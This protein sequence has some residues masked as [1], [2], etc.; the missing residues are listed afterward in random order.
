MRRGWRTLGA[1][2]A[3][4]VVYTLFFYRDLLFE[5]RVTVFRDQYA[6]LL[7]L[8][9]VVRFLS[10]WSW[11]PLWTPFQVL[12][13]PLAADPLAAVYYPPNWGLRLLPFPLGYNASL[14]VHHALAV[15]GLY[16]LLRRRGSGREAAAF[17]GLLFGFG[18][19]FVAFDNMSNAVQSSTWLP[20][21]LV[22]FDAWCER[23]RGSRLVAT[24]GGL[25]LTLLGGMPEVFFFAQALCAAIALEHRRRGGPTLPRAALALAAANA[26]GIGFGAVQ[27][28]PTAEY[29]LRSSRVAGLELESVMRLAL[30]PLGL[31]AFLV[32]RHYVDAAGAFHETAALWE[33]DFSDAPWALTL[34]LGPLLVVAAAA[35]IERR[36]LLLWSAIGVAFL[37]LACGDALPGYRW[38]IAHLP[39]LRAARH[40]EKFLLVA[41][42]L[43][44][45]VAAVGLDA[46]CRDPSRFRRIALAALALALTGGA[47]AAVLG[48]RPSLGRDLLRGDLLIAGA[49]ALLIAGVALVGRR[50]P[51]LAAGALL[52]LAAADLYRVNGRLL[53]TVDWSELRRVPPTL[54]AMQRGDDPLRIYSDGVGRPPVAPFPDAFH[55]ERH[56]LLM[57][58]ANLFAVANLNAPASINL[59]DHE[60]LA[61]LIESLPAERVAPL[62]AALNT[63]YVTSGKDLRRYPGLELARAP[64]SAIDAYVYRVAGVAPRA[65]V[66]AEIEPVGRAEDAID[67]LRRASA[68][69]ARVAVAAADVPL[70]GIPERMRGTVT[71]SAYRA[72]AV[73]VDAAMD[74]AGL[75]VLSDTFYPG[76]EADVDGAPAPI[77]RANYFSRGV[78]VDRGAH[79]IV[80]RYRPGSH[81][82]GLLASS[83]ALLI[84]LALILRR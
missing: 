52:A 57:E 62:F 83:L 77:V 44:A 60:R 34:Y 38:T 41:H 76:W 45:A 54:Q 20:W 70:G 66:P 49:L 48:L 22:A 35:R 24:A 82:A 8:D 4:L 71:L 59:R 18:G 16:V 42:L 7:P 40:P 1:L 36:S 9:W 72:E 30:R 12:G 56:L 63:A 79:H 26:L 47:A 37:A 28:L 74:T 27:L 3:A 13:K 80:F 51:A 78:F 21:T 55:Q 33:G 39:L 46:A 61:E 2:A 65:Y 68:P 64:R 23:P 10:Q 15:L 17:G 81:R 32:P 67:Y 75:V 73:E 14:A 58:V 84:A 19:L 29:L 5:R 69:A 6:I 53:P 43:L 31:F 25:A 11:P 50:R